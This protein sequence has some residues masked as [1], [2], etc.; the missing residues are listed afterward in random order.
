MKFGLI[1]VN[2]GVGS[3]DQMVAVG[4]KAEAAGLE[5]L[6]TFEHTIVPNDYSSRYP[7]SAD[8]KMPVTPETNFVDPLVALS[9]IAASTERVRLGTGVNILPQANRN[10]F[11]QLSGIGVLA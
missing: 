11:L 3:V 2:V 4:K 7:Y 1:P 10:R 5:S 8:G 6:W 9:A